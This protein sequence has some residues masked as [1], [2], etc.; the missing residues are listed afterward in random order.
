[1]T[2]IFFR[3]SCEVVQLGHHLQNNVE[4][5]LPF[6]TPVPSIA[7]LRQ[8]PGEPSF[9]ICTCIAETTVEAIQETEEFLRDTMG[10]L[11]TNVIRSITI[12]RWRCDSEGPP[13]P[14]RNE[15]LEYSKDGESWQKAP[16]FRT[17][18]LHVYF[19]QNRQ[20]RP[21][22]GQEIVDLIKTQTEEPLGRQLFREA[23]MLKTTNPRS[24]LVIGVAAA[25]VGFKKLVAGLV[26][27]LRMDK[28]TRPLDTMLTSL[29]PTLPI[30]ITDRVGG[31]PIRP[32]KSLRI[33][34]AEANTLR[35]KLVHAGQ[36]PP[37]HAELD[38]M[39]RAISDFLWICDVYSGQAW[40]GGYIS[41][42][43][44]K[45]WDDEV[46]A[47]AGKARAKKQSAP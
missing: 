5:E 16:E 32:P 47:A 14:F 44:L 38:Q 36:Q 10:A 6:D 13:H 23:W 27:K 7:R 43:T 37:N 4:I 34:L 39:L 42:E 24:A 21:Q 20:L 40:A 35:N 33:K 22:I 1:M 25:E 11:Y 41:A 28:R 18:Q 29:L 3:C 12:L 26:P 30:P 45:S 9:A 19:S 31:R 46:T 2:K 15:K 17:F 8:K